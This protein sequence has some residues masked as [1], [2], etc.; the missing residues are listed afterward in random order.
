MRNYLINFK[1]SISKAIK[2][3]Q[4]NKNKTLLVVNDKGNLLGSISNSDIRKSI[5]L[6]IKKNEKISKIMNK[7]PIYIK[8]FD[9]IK[10]RNSFI[11]KGVG[12][13]PLLDKNNIVKQVYDAENFI[14]K[15]ENRVSIKEIYCLILAGGTGNRMRPYTSVLPKPLIPHKGKPMIDL[16]IERFS[17]YKIKDFIISVGYKKEILKHFLEYKYYY[18][19]LRLD[20]IEEKKPLGT[21]GCL[22][23]LKKYNIENF[24]VTN[25]DTI[26]DYNYNKIIN[27]HI[28]KNFDVTVVVT[29]LE[30][31]VSYGCCSIKKNFLK[32]INEK[33]KQEIDVNIGFYIF[34]KRILDNLNKNKKIDMPELIN[35]LIKKNY[36]VGIYKVDKKYWKDIGNLDALN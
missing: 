29:K 8:K 28:R 19:K 26:L 17:K 13:I 27:Y 3:I 32:K 9:K 16:I 34:S 6:N 11:D 36:R 21:A 25:C 33:P 10:I 22:Y 24:F 2:K 30:N 15:L 20:F 7:K 35:S 1:Q 12:L 4:R 14:G 31:Y 23:N 5:L 18:S